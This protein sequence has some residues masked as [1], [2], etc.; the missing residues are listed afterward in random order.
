MAACCGCWS[1]ITS[2]LGGG[3]DKVV[4][5]T[6][7]SWNVESMGLVDYDVWDRTDE[8]FSTYSGHHFVLRSYRSDTLKIL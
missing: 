6:A 5:T 7:F 4:E 1:T 3:V 2:P 8:K